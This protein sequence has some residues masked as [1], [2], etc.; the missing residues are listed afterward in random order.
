VTSPWRALPVINYLQAIVE[1][2]ASSR[3]QFLDHSSTDPQKIR[4]K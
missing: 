2:A 1:E 3:Q 4:P